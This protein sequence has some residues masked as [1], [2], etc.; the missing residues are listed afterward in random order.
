MAKDT[1]WAFFKRLEG[2]QPC[3]L[4]ELKPG[5]HIFVVY[6]DKFF[7]TASYT[8]ESV[9][10][11]TLGNT[12]EK[13]KDIEAQIKKKGMSFANP[14]QSIER[15]WHAIKKLQTDMQKK[16]QSVDELVKQ[17]DGILSTFTMV[18]TTDISGSV[19]NLGNGPVTST[20]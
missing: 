1:E 19:S 3:E 14:K 9:C 10:A 17:R 11:D 18:N 2:P 8:I 4:S 6:G 15:H 5:T 16:K 7:K 12:T 13:H 20:T